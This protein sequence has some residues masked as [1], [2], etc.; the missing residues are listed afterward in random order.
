[1]QSR[2]GDK[3]AK[4]ARRRPQPRPQQHPR[5]VDI[6]AK[7][8]VAP[9]TV[10]RVVN[11][12]GYVSEEVRERVRRV[13]A[14]LN[15]HPNGLARSLKRQ[16]TRV[17]GLLLPDIANPFSAELA[18]SI[19]TAL[20]DQGYSSFI[21]TSERSNRREQASLRALF[22]HRVDG[23]I[24]ATR[25]TK[26]G[27]E[28]LGGLTGRGL[29]MVLVGRTFNHPQ[30][31]RVTADH[32][33][34]GYDAVEHLIARGHRRIAFVGVTLTNGAGLR[35]FQGYLDAL[36]ENGIPIR[37]DLIVGPEQADGPSY[38][39]QADGYAGMKKLL[40]LKAR[41][42]AVFA[43]NDYTAIGA[44]LAATDAGL[45]IPD[46]LAVAGFD[47]VPLSAYCAPPLTTVD[48]MTAEQGR[49]AA[50]L[51]LERLGNEPPRERREITLDC[52]LV[53]RQST[54]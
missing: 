18:S 44:M 17:V 10:S 35:R 37:K 45:K 26:A 5:L 14:E 19:Q 21:T 53:V 39:T 1:M 31:D 24:V 43:R 42:T 20:L 47:N 34:G 41:P 38:S 48:Q 4:A 13:V 2:S 25:E 3:R 36:R 30:V 46:D 50:A 54:G 15:Y 8:G 28:L 33:R 9:M 7:A 12:S 32:W 52:C 49:R 51:I 6:A 22:E 40:A 16:S 29:P 23:I 11:E 27:N